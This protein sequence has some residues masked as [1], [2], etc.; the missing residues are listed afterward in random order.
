VIGR[1]G[2]GWRGAEITEDQKRFPTGGGGERNRHI[3]KP[4]Q[5]IS[6]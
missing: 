5:G 4:R 6:H 1:W 3:V 2:G